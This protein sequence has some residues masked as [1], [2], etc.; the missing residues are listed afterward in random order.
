M[1]WVALASVVAG[2]LIG[3]TG[4]E[5]NIWSTLG[6]ACAVWLAA[7]TLIDLWGRTRGNRPLE[8]AKRLGAGYHGMVVAH[9]GVAIVTFGVA[10]VSGYYQERDLR[11]TVGQSAELGGYRFELAAL[12]NVAGPNWDAEQ[13]RFNIYRGERLMSTVTPQKRTYRVSGQIMT[14]AG[15][16]NRWDAD[17]FIAMG[18]PLE[19][20][21]AIRL[22]I[23]P[24]LIGCGLGL[25]SWVLAARSLCWTRVIGC[26]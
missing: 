21:W 12:E 18:E 24:S 10:M 6:I 22:R 23:K 8:R 26:A 5:F 16:Y 7:G 14:E 11:M 13:T 3:L 4:G 20:A 25:W 9:L 15:I 1:K 2:I 17:L 19:G